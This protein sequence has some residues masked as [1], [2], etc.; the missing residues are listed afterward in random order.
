MKKTLWIIIALFVV[1]FVWLSAEREGGSSATGT[2]Q[3]KIGAA[4]PLTGNY[5]SIGENIKR[6]LDTA[7]RDIEAKDR[8]LSIELLYEDGC[9]PKDVTSAL[10]KLIAVNNVKVINQ[11]CAIGLVPSLEITEPKG[12]ISVGIAA[13]VGDVLGKQYYFSPNFAV[14][15]NA[16]TIADFAINTLKA[17]KA[18]FIYYN[19]QFGKDYRKYIGERFT[20]LG[21]Q[22]VGDEMTPLDVLDFRTNL[23]KIKE[24]KPDV[25]FVTQLTGA[26]GTVIKQTRDL[27]IQVPLIGNYQNEDPVVLS[28]AGAA[29]EGFI[30]SSADPSILGK[31]DPNFKQEFEEQY[32]VQPDVFASN[33][34]DA[35]QLEVAA[36]ASCKGDTAC[37]KTELHKVSDYRGVSGTITI[38]ENGIASKPTI[39]KIVKDGKFVQ[40]GN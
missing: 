20:E 5:A 12:V 19:T 28:V 1:V 8:S 35:L 30:I 23:T 9:Q 18:A 22:I 3:I 10:Q 6:G 16:G 39:F 13:N 36:Y 17:K 25:I 2:M 34:Y 38:D 33:A 11:F 15:T 37:M 24:G 40:Y 4:I 29:A 32:N 14:K 21:G 7:K 31:G 27:G 26:L